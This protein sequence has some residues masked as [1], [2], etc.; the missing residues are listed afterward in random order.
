MKAK[1]KNK[2]LIINIKSLLKK[3]IDLPPKKITE[4]NNLITKIF[5]YSA[6]KMSAN[7]ALPYSILNPETNSDSPSAKSNGARFVSA[8]Q[9]TSQI[10]ATGIIIKASQR[11]LCPS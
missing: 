4:E 6:R 10:K 2:T 9:V 11:L 3:T 7:P 5:A 8:T 1:A